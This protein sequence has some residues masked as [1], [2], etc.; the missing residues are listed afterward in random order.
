MK[1]KTIQQNFTFDRVGS[2]NE[3]HSYKCTI[4]LYQ[5]DY[6][7]FFFVPF[8]FLLF[9]LKWIQ[10]QF[11]ECGLNFNSTAYVKNVNQVNIATLQMT[12]VRLQDS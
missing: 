11:I 8:I 2:W 4:D 12:C 6:G 3:T 9:Y 1:N 5:M 7:W 10:S